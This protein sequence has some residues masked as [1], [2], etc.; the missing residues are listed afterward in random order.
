MSEDWTRWIGHKGDVVEGPYPVSLAAI[1]YL[2][3]SL[4]DERLADAVAAGADMAAPRSF[5]TIAS[6][7]P[8]WIR[9]G[10][11]GPRTFMQAVL[12]PLPA[13][14]AVNMAVEQVYE[15]PLRV[16]D[17]LVSQS[18]I[19]SIVPKRTRLGEGFI[20][21]EDIE[22]RN[23][24]GEV[25]GRTV[26]SLLRYRKEPAPAPTA[27]PAAGASKAAAPAGPPASDFPAI[28]LPITM[29]RLATAAAAVRD[30]SP[31][32]HD[33]EYARNAGHPT[34]FLSYSYQLAVACR[35]LGEWFDGD[36]RVTHL[37][38][39]MKAPM[40]LGK[41]LTC[42]G[43]RSREAAA[44]DAETIELALSTEDGLSTVAT[45]RVAAA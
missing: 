3:E 9:K 24:R 42:T 7:V 2:A 11:R 41:T 16:G 45:A 17:K 1:G 6:R 34:A 25:V 40:Y 26:N 36:A 5:M 10:Y 30:F 35:A 28:A 22:H 31:L 23:Q 43:R 39:S 21:T 19:T 8:N 33:I 14:A 38:V 15:A 18:T 29:T 32:H 37:K 12:L 13:D 20:V 27:P 4:E 44:A